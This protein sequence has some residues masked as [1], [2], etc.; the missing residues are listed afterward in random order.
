M[1]RSEILRTADSTINGA[2]QDAYGRPE[3]NFA[4][5]AD[6]WTAYLGEDLIG[7][8]TAVD[9]ALMMVLFKAARCKTGV[10]TEDSFID[11]CGYG[12][13]GGEMATGGGTVEPE[14]GCDQCGECQHKCE[15]DDLPKRLQ[16]ML[17]TLMFKTDDDE[18]GEDE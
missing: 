8:L 14:A 2:R 6:L 13:I 5:I 9:V 16:D 7:S 3:A 4:R 15:K 11:L 17:I 12:A 10:G 1:H 18:E